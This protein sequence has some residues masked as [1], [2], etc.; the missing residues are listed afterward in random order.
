MDMYFVAVVLPPDLN[1]KIFVWKQY[2]FQQYKCAVGLKSPAHITIIPPFWMHPEKEKDFIKNI[3][4][5]SAQI[6]QFIIETNDFSAFKPRTIFIAVKEN[7]H[8]VELKRKATEFFEEKDYNIKPENRSFHPH[9]TIAT[10]DLYK[11]DFHETW[12][13]FQNKK[14]ME[15]WQTNGLSILHHNK[16]NWDVIY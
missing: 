15:E 10:R 13:L 11:K 7:L 16:K 8:L 1:E 3:D 5:L 14:F 6:S 2:M 4:N 12:N 9:I